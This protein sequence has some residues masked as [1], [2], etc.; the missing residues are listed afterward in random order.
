MVSYASSIPCRHRDLLLDSEQRECSPYKG[1]LF[2]EQQMQIL[3]LWWWGSHRLEGMG[4]SRGRAVASASRLSYDAVAWNHGDGC[5]W[6]DW[7]NG[8]DR[9]EGG[10]G[11]EG[12]HARIEIVNEAP[13]AVIVEDFRWNLG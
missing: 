12:E 9:L 3:G 6:S 1:I 13:G 4:R 11:I 5:S 8:E 2:V 7:S 10:S